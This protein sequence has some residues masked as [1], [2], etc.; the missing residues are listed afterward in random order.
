[1]GVVVLL[2]AFLIAPRQTT[3]PWDFYFVLVGPILLFDVSALLGFVLC[4]L[5][6]HSVSFAYPL[7]SVAVAIG[8]WYMTWFELRLS[9]HL[10]FH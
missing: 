2:I 3:V 9:W 7:I 10:L 6:G 1:M 4:R 8:V 5:N